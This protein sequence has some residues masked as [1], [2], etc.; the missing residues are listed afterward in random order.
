MA[1]IA[2]SSTSDVPFTSQQKAFIMSLFGIDVPSTPNNDPVTPLPQATVIPT[3]MQTRV[4]AM[5]NDIK[6]SAHSR[7]DN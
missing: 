1:A 4:R 5:M 2:S 7:G 6:A 3:S